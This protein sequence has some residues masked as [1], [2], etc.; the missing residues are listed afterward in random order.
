M[1]AIWALGLALTTLSPATATV[2][3]SPIYELSLTVHEGGRLIATPRLTV[4]DG[5]EAQIVIGNDA[6]PLKM[7][8]RPTGLADG[9]TSVALTAERSQVRD[10]IMHRKRIE[11]TVVVHAGEQAVISPHTEGSDQEPLRLTLRVERAAS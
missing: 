10:E 5:N 3:A 6:D 11:T 9:T 8:L 4:G 1:R 2:P 7:T